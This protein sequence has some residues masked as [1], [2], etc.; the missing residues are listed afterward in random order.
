VE[1]SEIPDLAEME[2]IDVTLVVDEQGN[3]V[4]GGE[5][6]MEDLLGGLGGLGGLEGFTQGSQ[7]GGFVGPPLSDEEVAVGDSW[8]ETVEVPLFEEEVHATEIVST[9]TGTDTIEGVEVLV[10]ETT[11][12][13][14]EIDFDIG[15]MLIGMF[16][17]F[18]PEDPTEEE[19]AELE[20]ITDQ[21]RFHFLIAPS[22]SNMTTHFDAGAGRALGS[23]FSGST[24]MD[25]DINV[26]DEESGEMISFGMS[27]D[28][29]QVLTYRL[30]DSVG[31]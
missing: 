1:S 26:P 4:S 22:V 27:M 20:A 24:Q 14:G 2:P 25:M 18:L 31:A 28:L 16:E 15:E 11:I 9:V 10:I 8:S 6:G 21:L 17:A 3:L 23:E 30:V 12:S 19:L 29:S 7:L 13:S 5:D